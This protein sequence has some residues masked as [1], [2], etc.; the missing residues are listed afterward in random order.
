MAGAPAKRTS[1]FLTMTDSPYM[2]RIATSHLRT[3]AQGALLVAAQVLIVFGIWTTRWFE[4]YDT[5]WFHLH[6]AVLVV[7]TA[8]ALTCTNVYDGKSYV[9]SLHIH[10]LQVFAMLAVYA[11]GLLMA[12]AIRD[13]VNRPDSGEFRER[14]GVVSAVAFLDLWRLGAFAFAV[15]TSVDRNQSPNTASGVFIS[16]S[17]LAACPSVAPFVSVQSDGHLGVLVA[18]EPGMS[19]RRGDRTQCPSCKSERLG[20]IP[21]PISVMT[22]FIGQTLCE[23]HSVSE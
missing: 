12:L 16:A 23:R 21:S 15:E 4:A 13:V 8:T 5:T 6:Y 11:S 17:G 1:N 14:L 19:R 10:V 2:C 20:Q 3:L 22:P 18:K 9:I 7:E